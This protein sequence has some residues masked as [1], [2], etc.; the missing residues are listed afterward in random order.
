ME[1]QNLLFDLFK[2]RIKIKVILL[3]TDENLISLVDTNK[4]KVKI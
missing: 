2:L 1:F 3:L 4:V